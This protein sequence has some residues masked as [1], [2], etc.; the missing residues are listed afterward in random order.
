MPISRRI[1]KLVQ[2][3]KSR[4]MQGGN[5]PTFHVVI[6]TAGRQSLMKMLNS[7]KSQL[8]ENDALTLL[9]DGQYAKEKS[10]Y[11]DEYGKSMKCKVN[12]I[13]QIPGL[14]MYGHPTI[15]KY[16]PSLQPE[17]TYVMFADD[18]DHYLEGA[19]DTLRKKCVDPDI[20][21]IAK[22]RDKHIIV[23]PFG[24]TTIDLGHISKQCGIIPFK[25][26][27]KSK[28]ALIREGDFDYYNELKDKV[29]GLIFLDDIIYEVTPAA[30]ANG[31]MK[32]GGIPRIKNKKKITRRKQKRSKRIIRRVF[33]QLGGFEASSAGVLKVAILFAGRI[34]A[35]QHVLPKLLEI[36][37]TY[38]PVIFCSLN[39]ESNTPED[40]KSFCAEFNIPEE[41]SNI[42]QTVLP[43]WLNSCRP[44][45]NLSNPPG[46]YSMF[47]H[48][49]KAFHL[50]E[51]YQ[52][53]NSMK[54]DCVLYYRADMD[55][56]E[57][58]I[59]S[60]PENN[61]I[62]IPN[63]LDYGGY[64][65]RMAYGSYE[66]MKVYCN[67]IHSLEGIYCKNHALN[68]P[69]SI[70]KEYLKNT[71]MKITTIAYNTELHPLRNEKFEKEGPLANP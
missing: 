48:E 34:K 69:E 31:N 53:K 40:I 66:S 8:T 22:M 41:Q 35:Y 17:T 2:R 21:Y 25:D 19:F 68:N 39:K 50:I 71:G 43:P 27:D 64:N 1:K 30:N 26:K 52:E 63:T 59:M 6:A 56:K 28:I 18:D 10:T 55:S 5:T 16:L 7:L 58:L 45:A 61:T 51:K 4:R 32:G 12:V 47:Y 37:N 29:K 33:G 3:G 67:L 62:Y 36:Q 15:N 9:F 70:L 20:L 46:V 13:E 14:E 23:P 11:K 24:H 42:E 60:M 49:N 54:F 57:K 44:V 38:N 65:D